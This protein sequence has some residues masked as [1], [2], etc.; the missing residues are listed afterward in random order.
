M[1]V[2]LSLSASLTYFYFFT[3][4]L[5]LSLSLS[6]YLCLS[7]SLSASLAV[8]ISLF[9]FLYLFSCRYC[10]PSFRPP[11][12]KRSFTVS[13]FLL[14]FSPPSPL[15]FLIYLRIVSFISHNVQINIDVSEYASHLQQYQCI[16]YTNIQT[17]YIYRVKEFLKKMYSS[18]GGIC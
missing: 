11:K 15:S 16:F 3:R 4:H 1:V 7:L 13:F 9:I 17:L 6:L 18:L 10:C 2:F 12:L 14:S 5:F 8:Y